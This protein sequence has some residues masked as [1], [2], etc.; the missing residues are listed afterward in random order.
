MFLLHAAAG[1]ACVCVCVFILYARTALSWGL[2]LGAAEELI[3]GVP[4]EHG[5]CNPLNPALLS[6]PLHRLAGPSAAALH[7]HAS[8]RGLLH[9]VAAVGCHMLGDGYTS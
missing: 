9:S 4:G 5:R 6:G 1:A 7:L 3:R 8:R 2:V